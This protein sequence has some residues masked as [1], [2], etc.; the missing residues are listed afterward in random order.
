M[1][2]RR[3]WSRSPASLRPATSPP[4]WQKPA[5]SCGC[6]PETSAKTPM[7]HPV[8]KTIAAA[9]I[10]VVL[11]ATAAA[12][13]VPAL[14]HAASGWSN[15]PERLPALSENPQVHFQAGGIEQARAVAL[16]QPAAIA[17]VEQVQ[18]RPFA[19]P[20][21]IGVYLSPEDFVAANG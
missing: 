16:L 21:T 19:H 9:V 11:L 20:P 1:A 5:A 10:G 17:R 7:P 4:R 2:I 15:N 3:T 12:A 8:A 13:A 14:R 6:R 18:G